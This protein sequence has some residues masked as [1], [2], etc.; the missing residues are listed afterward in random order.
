MPHKLPSQSRWLTEARSVSFL[1]LS[2]IAHHKPDLT[3]ELPGNS[4][5]NYRVWFLVYKAL[6]ITFGGFRPPPAQCTHSRGLRSTKGTGSD[7]DAVESRL[8]P[9]ENSGENIRGLSWAGGNW[10]LRFLEEA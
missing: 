2:S 4:L 3:M 6:P 8:P 9:V 1:Q 5:L 10:H 7:P